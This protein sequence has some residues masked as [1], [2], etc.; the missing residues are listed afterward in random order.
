MTGVGLVRAVGQVAVVV[1]VVVGRVLHLVQDDAGGRHAGPLQEADTV[2]QEGAEHLSDQRPRLLIVLLA[3]FSHLEQSLS[4][5]GTEHGLAA[6]SEMFSLTKWL[7]CPTNTREYR[8]RYSLTKTC[9]QVLWRLLFAL[10]L[11]H[12]E[13]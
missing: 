8:G 12:Q 7:N 3:L 5:P 10:I 4:S 1:L 6:R 2:D 13:T 11:N 9:P